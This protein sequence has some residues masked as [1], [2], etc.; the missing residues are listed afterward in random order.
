MQSLPLQAHRL[1]DGV[2]AVAERITEQLARIA[3][4]SKPVLQWLDSAENV[5]SL[6]LK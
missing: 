4:E 2:R 1:D 5:S 3:T 6:H